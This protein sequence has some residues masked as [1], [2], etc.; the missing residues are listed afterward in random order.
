MR[1]QGCFGFAL[2]HLKAGQ[3][4]ARDGW[5]GKGQWIRL[6]RPDENSKMKLPYLYIS[7]QNYRGIIVKWVGSL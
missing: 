3:S 1:E 6:Q 4:V 5:N 2:D 7:T